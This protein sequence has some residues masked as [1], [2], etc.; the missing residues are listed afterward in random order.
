MVTLER[1]VEEINP[2]E[3]HKDF[4]L[5]LTSMPSKAF[6]VSVLQNGIKMTN[7]PPKGLR[8]NLR[9]AYWRL[10]DDKLNITSKPF[11]YKKLLWGLAVFHAVVQER[12]QFGPLGWN[13]PYGFND[14]DWVDELVQRTDF[15]T[16]WVKENVAPVVWI[17]G[18]YFP[19]AF[20]TGTLQN[21]ARKH[22]LPIDTIDF[23]FVYKS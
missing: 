5:W 2:D 9:N 11:E 6:P 19:Q 20:L 23:D 17:S 10:S 15:I 22:Q 12:R 4:R 1:L 8:A 14:T 16:K 3:T 13:I 7:E 18:F 21:Y